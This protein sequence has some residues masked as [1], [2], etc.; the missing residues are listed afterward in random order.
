MGLGTLAAAHA[1]RGPSRFTSDVRISYYSTGPI[2][3]RAVISSMLLLYPCAFLLKY[4]SD[5]PGQSV[6]PVEGRVLRSHSRTFRE[7]PT[8][9]KPRVGEPTLADQAGIQISV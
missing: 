3:S 9:R 7:V 1:C 5:D 2:A 4:L 6:W 8:P